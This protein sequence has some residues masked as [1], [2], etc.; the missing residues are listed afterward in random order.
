MLSLFKPVEG[1]KVILP[2]INAYCIDISAEYFQLWGITR[3]DG[4][5]NRF[6]KQAWGVLSY[7]VSAAA[8]RKPG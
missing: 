5:T 2:P 7:D 1:G 8:R 6:L 3:A 4:R